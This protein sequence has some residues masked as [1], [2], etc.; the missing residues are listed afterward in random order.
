[1]SC[2]NKDIPDANKITFIG[3]RGNNGEDTRNR[4]ESGCRVDN[5]RSASVCRSFPFSQHFTDKLAHDQDCDEWPPALAQQAAFDPNPK[6]RP[7]NSLRCMPDSE[8]RSLGAKLGNIV[9]GASRDDFFRVDFTTNIGSADQSKVKYCLN[10]YNGNTEPDCTQDGHQFGM[11]QKSVQN[12]KIS[13]PYDNGKGNDNRYKFLGT[14]YKEVYQCSV[15]FSRDGDKN[16][17]SVVL[18]DWENED[19]FVKDFELNN[20]GDTYLMEGLPQGLQIKRT[21]NFGSKFEYFYAPANPVGQ[22][23]NEFQWDSDMEGEGRGPAT[24]A[25]NS[26]RFCYVKADGANKNIEE[27][28]FP[29][30]RNANG[31]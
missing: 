21:G 9:R 20:N 6:V 14:P 23:I 16:I 17:R 11:V 26:N 30:Y 24:D 27:C 5:D 28:W 15:K 7:P 12:G 19:H 22:N 4:H 31:R 25:G 8:N 2:Q 1:L 10:T 13:S 3:P 18:S 29:C